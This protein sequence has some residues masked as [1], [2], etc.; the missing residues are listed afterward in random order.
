MMVSDIVEYCDKG[1]SS[2]G[3]G[4]CGLSSPDNFEGQFIGGFLPSPNFITPTIKSHSARTITNPTSIV[5]Y[6]PQGIKHQTYRTIR[7]KKS[8]DLNMSSGFGID[9]T[10]GYPTREERLASPSGWTPGRHP[11]TAV[12]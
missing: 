9:A 12:R 3:I 7:K 1:I 5:L 2:N 6:N 8:R 10:T 11:S 4:I